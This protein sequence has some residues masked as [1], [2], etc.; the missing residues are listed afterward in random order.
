MEVYGKQHFDARNILGLKL[1]S[2]HGSPLEPEKLQHRRASILVTRN[3]Q[4]WGISALKAS[5]IL[6]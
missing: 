6:R 1:Q 5:A 3:V 2:W 4:Q